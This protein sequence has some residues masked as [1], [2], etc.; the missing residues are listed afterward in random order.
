MLCVHAYVSND[1]F[2]TQYF[3]EVLKIKFQVFISFSSFTLLISTARKQSYVCTSQNLPCYYM[4]I[5]DCPEKDHG[6]NYFIHFSSLSLLSAI[7]TSL[8]EDTLANSILELSQGNIGRLSSILILE[9]INHPLAGYQ[10]TS[11]FSEWR[12]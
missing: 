3:T 12:K 4:D 10:V 6:R 7:Q 1:I 2:R 5:S 8:R 11:S 9:H